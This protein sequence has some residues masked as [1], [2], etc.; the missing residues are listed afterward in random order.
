MTN[1]AAHHLVR[2]EVILVNLAGHENHLARPD[3][4]YLVVFIRSGCNVAEVASHAQGLG[5]VL[6]SG[7]Q[8]RG[9]DVLEHLDVLINFGRFFPIRAVQ[10][11]RRTLIRGAALRVHRREE[12]RQHRAE[13]E[14]TLKKQSHSEKHSSLVKASL[15]AL[16]PRALQ[17]ASSGD[18]Q[19]PWSASSPR[20]S[21][22]RPATNGGRS[23][24]TLQSTRLWLQSATLSLK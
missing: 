12:D 17:R 2:T 1:D 4:H 22:A 9:I 15:A 7:N 23:C 16:H 20:S 10:A 13:R 19:H 8:F 5:H 18:R 14:R 21:G 3:L 24:L 6:H 11:L